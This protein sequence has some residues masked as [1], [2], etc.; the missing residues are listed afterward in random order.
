MHQPVPAAIEN[1]VCRMRDLADLPVRAL[2]LRR[3]A[4]ITDCLAYAAEVRGDAY[5][6]ARLKLEA[7]WLDARADHLSRT[8]PFE[9]VLD[10]AITANIFHEHHA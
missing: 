6:A 2:R 3:H 8:P 7:L 10:E 9:A 4:E 5:D 1:R